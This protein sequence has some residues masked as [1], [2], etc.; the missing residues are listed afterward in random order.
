[1]VGPGR[2][3]IPWGGGSECGRE[4]LRFRQ[5]LS[6]RREEKDELRVC[7]LKRLILLAEVEEKRECYT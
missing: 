3:G 7:F 6:W 2:R 4:A 5:V 1:M